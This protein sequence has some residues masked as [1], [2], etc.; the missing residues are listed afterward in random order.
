MRPGL[1]LYCSTGLATLSSLKLTSARA[2]NFDD[3]FV[4]ELPTQNYIPKIAH[5]VFAKTKPLDW[6]EYA[7]I[8]SAIVNLQA[9]QV[10]LWVP[11]GAKFEGHIW[12]LVL[13]LPQITFREIEMP[14]SVYG[15]EVKV[16]AHVSDIVRLEAVYNEGGR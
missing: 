3:I 8:K 1:L 4:D 16:L 15:H 14:T 12:S 6:L 10:R 9:E 13:G 5:F 2:V 11:P 7:S